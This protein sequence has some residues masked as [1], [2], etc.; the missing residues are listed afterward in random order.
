VLRRALPV[1]IAFG[2]VLAIVLAVVSGLIGVV[3]GVVSF[4][5]GVVDFFLF[6]ALTLPLWRWVGRRS[7]AGR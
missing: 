2:V 3:L 6:G 5:R 1:R 4:L 7:R